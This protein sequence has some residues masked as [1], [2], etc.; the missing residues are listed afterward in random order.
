MVHGRNAVLDVDDLLLESDAVPG[1]V[2]GEA[3]GAVPE[4]E[5]EVPGDPIRPEVS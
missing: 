2:G 1:A 4:E 3:V 5:T